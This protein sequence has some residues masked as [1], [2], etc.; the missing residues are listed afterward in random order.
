MAELCR[1]Q[2]LVVRNKR[3][4]VLAVACGRPTI[5]TGAKSACLSV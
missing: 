4:L 1:L 3:Q 2:G 5:S